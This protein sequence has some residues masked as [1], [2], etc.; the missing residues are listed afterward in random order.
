MAN[1]HLED[2]SCQERPKVHYL[3]DF[4]DRKTV[5]EYGTEASAVNE[6]DSSVDTTFRRRSQTP[7]CAQ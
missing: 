3:L 7:T 6:C 1:Q 4:E 2:F 5:A